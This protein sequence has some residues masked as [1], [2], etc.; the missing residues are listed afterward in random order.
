MT[1]AGKI[2][3][4]PLATHSFPMSQLPEAFK[5]AAEDKSAIKIMILQE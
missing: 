5:T 2:D 3:L 4:T 1:A